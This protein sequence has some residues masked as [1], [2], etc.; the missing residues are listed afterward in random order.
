[1]TWVRLTTWAPA[2][3]R[4]ATERPSRAPSTTKSLISAIASGWLSLTPRSSRRRA[5]IAAMEMSSL[6][7]SRGVRFMSPS[8]SST[9]PDARHRFAAQR[10]DQADQVGAERLAGRREQPGDEHAVPGADAGLASRIGKRRAGRLEPRRRIR[11][12]QDGSGKGGGAAAGCRSGHHRR[13]VA[14]EAES[15]GKH[16]AAVPS[17]APDVVESGLPYHLAHR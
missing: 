9:G 11:R 17:D 15:V 12:D 5:T 2:D 7:F 4:S 10:F 3:M 16:Q 13:G 14:V 6:S 1:M 8:V